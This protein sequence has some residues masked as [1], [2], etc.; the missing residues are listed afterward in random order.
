MIQEIEMGK[1]EPQVL[2][3][4]ELLI[5]HD[6]LRYQITQLHTIGTLP[7]FDGSTPQT[8]RP[9]GLPYDSSKTMGMASKIW[10]NVKEGRVLVSTSQGETPR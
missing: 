1:L 8:P 6:E 5:K 4:T 3:T 10:K 2:A 9:S 7:H